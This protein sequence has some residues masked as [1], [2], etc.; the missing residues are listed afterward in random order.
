MPFC[1]LNP[2]LINILFLQ[3]LPTA[4]DK[5]TLSLV[6][7]CFKNIVYQDKNGPLGVKTLRTKKIKSVKDLTKALIITL[8]LC[9]F[10]DV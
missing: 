7:K 3:F 4:A 2:N 8:S 5:K 9:G 1:N 10:C 6:C